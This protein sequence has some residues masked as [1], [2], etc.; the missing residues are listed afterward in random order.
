[1]PAYVLKRSVYQ[2]FTNFIFLSYL[3]EDI[4]LWEGEFPETAFHGPYSPNLET[5]I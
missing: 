3:E 5:L 4:I 1:M 2:V